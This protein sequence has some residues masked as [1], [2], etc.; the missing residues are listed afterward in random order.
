MRTFEYIQFLR[1][2]GFR[3]SK[4]ALGFIEFGQKY[5]ASSDALVIVA[6][7]MTLRQQRTFDGSYFIALLERLH[8]EKIADAKHAHVFLRKL[9]H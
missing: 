9:E 5:T 2:K 4:D 8:Q 1:T 7:E 6:I 3:L